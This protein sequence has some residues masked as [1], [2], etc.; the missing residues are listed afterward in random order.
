[1]P[2]A[3]LQTYI[4]ALRNRNDLVEINTYVD[5]Y[6]EIPEIHR[7]VIA[8]SG[9]ALL[10]TNVQG[11]PYP[12]ATNLFGTKERVELA[13]AGAG[14]N[15]IANIKQVIQDLMPPL[16]FDKL[17]TERGFLNKFLTVGTKYT[18][19]SPITSHM[20]I[21]PML[22]EL[23]VL[24]T[25]KKD[26]GPFLTLP[27]VYTEHPETGAHNL[28]MY[29]MQI[30]DNSHTGMHMQIGRGGGFHL[31]RARQLNKNL[32]VNVFLG[33]PPTAILAA[34]APMPENM[35]ELMLASF[36]LDDKIKLTH[37]PIGPLPLLAQ[38]EFAL[39]GYVHPEQVLPEG[40]FG[41][42]YGYYSLQ[43]EYPVFTCEAVFNRKN[44]IF[45]A[46]I[47]GKP[48]QEDY[49]IGNYVQELLSPL[50]PLAM[51]TVKN[52]W[53]YG[54]TGYHSLAAAVVEERYKREAMVSAFRILGEGQL[55][56]TK[57][58][59]LIDREMDLKNFRGVLEYILERTDFNTDFFVFSNLS[60]DTLD[61]TGPKINEGSKAVMLG[62]GQPVRGLPSEFHGEPPA[63]ITDV[64]VFCSG[65]LVVSGPSFSED[66]EAPERIANTPTFFGWPLIIF[67]DDAKF[68]T[69]TVQN[70]L[71]S[72]FT[73]FEPAAD[74]YSRSTTVHRFHPR[75]QSPVVIDAR[76]KPGF[77][78][79]VTCDEETKK[80]VD[81]R[82]TDYFSKR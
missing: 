25:W 54:E 28:G 71:W 49:F 57:F 77:P 76:T 26:G 67:A 47:V 74:I 64:R 60:M 65:C 53:S 38:A 70:F 69:S 12:V 40:P 6:L 80:L 72:T 59:L 56:L 61:Y 7:R 16:N 34:I 18:K 22:Q 68:S 58:L 39:V 45:P 62:M 5:P 48:C 1:M 29:R 42:H 13:F 37:N 51:P 79:E 23:P 75:L 3:D 14:A 21:P 4:T 82:W 27:L 30:Y 33:G 19:K 36:L 66:P 24:T 9:P 55:S 63:N 32:P 52:L 43:H 31:H 50:F 73:R 2:F 10:F 17:W 15:F 44:P 11:S 41:D 35:P 8:E 46:T 78:E 81:A 20:Q